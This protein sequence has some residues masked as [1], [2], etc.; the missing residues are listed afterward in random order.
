MTVKSME[1]KS[2]DFLPITS[3]NT[4]LVPTSAGQYT[5]STFTT[6]MTGRA[7]MCM[8][9]R[10]TTRPEM[11]FMD[12]YWRILKKILLFSGFKNPYRKIR[13]TRKLESINEHHCVEQ[14]N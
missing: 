7:G 3:K 11:K 14:K 8:E 6:D 13:K 4:P 5:N 2:Q 10:V 12:I 9:L 1:Q